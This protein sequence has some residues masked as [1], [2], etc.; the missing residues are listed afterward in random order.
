[1]V[2]GVVWCVFE[3]S[4][5]R[6]RDGKFGAFIKFRSVAGKLYSRVVVHGVRMCVCVCVCVCAWIVL[7]V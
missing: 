6:G 2:L 7:C 3:G 4:V 5:L 1:M